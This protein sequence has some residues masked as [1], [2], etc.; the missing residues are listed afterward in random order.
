MFKTFCDTYTCVFLAILKDSELR[1]CISASMK[2]CT[3]TF[4]DSRISC[5]VCDSLYYNCDVCDGNVKFIPGNDQLTAKKV[6][7]HGFTPNTYY[8]FKVSEV[9][10]G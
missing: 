4:S 8:K 1:H 6:E 5:E 3:I 2:N 7:V 10:L 9:G